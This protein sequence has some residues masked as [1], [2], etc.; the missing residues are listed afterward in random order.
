MAK[1]DKK[2]VYNA[3]MGA[4]KSSGAEYDK[5]NST[6]TGRGDTTWDRATENYNP[7]YQGYMDYAQGGGLTPEDKARM[8]GAMD[9]YQSAYGGGGGSIS[10]PLAGKNSN[11]KGLSSAYSSAYRP[12]YGEADTGFRKLAGEGGGFDAD[13]L[14]QIYGNVG[15][16][17]KIGETGGVTKEDYDNINRASILEQEKTGG[18]SDQDRAMIRAKSAASSPAYFQTLKD[19]LERQRG[20]TGNLANA[21]AVDFKLARQS[22]QQQGQD[23]VGAEIALGDSI[24]TG[25]ESAGQFLSEQNLDLYDRRTKNAIQGAQAGG[26]LGLDTQMGI[27]KNQAEGLKGLQGSQT[28]L[29]DWG[30]G[31]AGGLD[32]FSLNQAGGLDQWDIS[33]ASMDMQAQQSNN[34]SSAAGSRAAAEANLKY[35]QWLTEYGNEQKQYGLG[36][37]NDLYNTNLTASRDFTGMGLEGLSGKYGTQGSMLGLASQNRGDTLGETVGK[38]GK[39]A[40]AAALTYM[41]GGAAAPLLVDSIG[42]LGASSGAGTGYTAAPAMGPRLW[43][44]QQYGSGSTIAGTGGGMT[45]P[46]IMTGTGSTQNT[47]LVNRN[48]FAPQG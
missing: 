33:N 44:Q 38:Y 11:Y 18:Y 24:R 48:Y 14:K 22:A 28:G 6:I 39:V 19:N 32:N 8:Q 7:T 29:G 5:L 2:D 42:G 35:N 10:N 26:A 16:L 20:Q 37:L 36:G 30:L 12:D 9:Q 40:G 34:A 13:Q 45:N 3:S 4:V 25:R 1:S 27:T 15:N 21:G 43:G 46:N 31:Q 41:S 17:S 47:G 23:R